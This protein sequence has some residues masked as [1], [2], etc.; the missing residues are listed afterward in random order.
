[1]TI[2]LSLKEVSSTPLVQQHGNYC[3]HCVSNVEIKCG[4]AL[5]PVTNLPFYVENFKKGTL[6]G[7]HLP[8]EL[9]GTGCSSSS[10]Y[11]QRL[12]RQNHMGIR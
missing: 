10:G 9:K 4:K 5:I 3:H 12:A 8:V 2:A 11:E 7:A 1:M 6:H